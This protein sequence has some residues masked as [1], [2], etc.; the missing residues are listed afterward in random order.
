MQVELKD[1]KIN[2]EYLQKNFDH[3]SMREKEM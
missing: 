1:L 3:F 2:N